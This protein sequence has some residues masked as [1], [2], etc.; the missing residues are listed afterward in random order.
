[1]PN[2]CALTPFTA[3]VCRSKQEKAKMEKRMTADF[4]TDLS[5]FIVSKYNT[6]HT[7]KRPCNVKSA[8]YFGVRKESRTRF[9]EEC[10]IELLKTSRNLNDPDIWE[11][12]YAN[13][14][15]LHN[16]EISFNKV[17]DY[18][19][20]ENKKSNDLNPSVRSLI[21]TP[22]FYYWNLMKFGS[23]SRLT[24][25]C[26]EEILDTFVNLDIQIQQNP[27][28]EMYQ[29][30]FKSTCDILFVYCNVKNFFRPLHLEKLSQ[31]KNNDILSIVFEHYLPLLFGIEITQIS[32]PL[33]T[34]EEF[35][36]QYTSSSNTKRKSPKQE[37]ED[38][39]SILQDTYFKI[40]YGSINTTEEFKRYL[41]NFC[42]EKLQESKFFMNKKK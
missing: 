36:I 18:Y 40:Y 32:L 4:E 2:S 35:Y 15:N 34:T 19:T 20:E 37:L 21:F 33:P 31:C 22:K 26:F 28:N 12:L 17:F 29:F 11:F 9:L 38:W 41:Y 7:K 1:M 24:T 16:P 30:L 5:L 3:K 10:L 27:D 14:H 6:I 39:L 23:D 8:C 13:L 42:D 25:R